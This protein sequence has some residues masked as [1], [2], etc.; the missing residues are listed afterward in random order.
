VLLAST[1]QTIFANQ[2]KTTVDAKPSPL[3]ASSALQQ[4][5]EIRQEVA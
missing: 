4:S 1:H 2:R 5:S 3:L